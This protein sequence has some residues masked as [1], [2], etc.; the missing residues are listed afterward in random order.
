MTASRKSATTAALALTALLAVGSAH[1]GYRMTAFGDT[2]GFEEIMSENYDAASELL[3]SR[4]AELNRYARH[5]NLCVSLLKS[6]DVDG[7]M[8]SCQRALS[9]A[10]TDLNS[11]L[12]MGTGKRT[13]IMTHLYSNRGVV[14]AVAGDVFGARADFE[15]ALSL[16][17]D[18][19]NA[20]ANLEVISASG[21]AGTAN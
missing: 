3:D 5:A 10:P 21:I 6:K 8:E 18:N 2:L 16:D 11:S 4:R 13:A 20:R 1:A 9:V 12:L 7:A 15:R 17:E 14:R 19:A